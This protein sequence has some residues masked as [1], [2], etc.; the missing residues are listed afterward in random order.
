MV[1]WVFLNS[2]FQDRLVFGQ[3]VE[4]AYKSTLFLSFVKGS[5]GWRRQRDASGG[6][7]ERD[8]PGLGKGCKVLQSRMQEARPPREGVSSRL[9]LPCLSTTH[10]PQSRKIPREREQRA[11]PR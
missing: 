5:G 1:V 11:S 2:A 3:K 4:A 9:R 8:V 6:G 7:R 10:K